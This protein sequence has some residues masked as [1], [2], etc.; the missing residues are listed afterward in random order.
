MHLLYAF[1]FTNVSVSQDRGIIS[2][3]YII[4]FVVVVIHESLPAKIVVSPLVLGK[5]LCLQLALFTISFIFLIEFL[6]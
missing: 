5:V 4:F 6:I 2:L 3:E 1:V